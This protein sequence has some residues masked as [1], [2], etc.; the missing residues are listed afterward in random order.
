MAASYADLA[1][2][3]RFCGV[4]GVTLEPS[5]SE[6][7]DWLQALIIGGIPSKDVEKEIPFLG[8]LLKKQEDIDLLQKTGKSHYAYNTSM[9]TR[10][11]Y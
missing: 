8:T 6:L 3:T 1:P 9:R 2:D 5:T 7:I 4:M 11:V 10:D